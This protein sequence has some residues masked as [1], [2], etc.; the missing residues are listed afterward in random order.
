MSDTSSPRLTDSPWYWAYLFAMA[1]LIALVLIGPKFARRQAIIET[2]SE[3]R[4]RASMNL[5][6]RSL[7]PANED[8]SPRIPLG[9]LYLVLALLLGVAGFQLWRRRRRGAGPH[10]PENAASPSSGP[11]LTT[12]QLP[13]ATESASTSIPRASPAALD[14]PTQ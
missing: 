2:K 9:P 6:G 13:A 11:G 1:G 3:A 12:P 5:S 8:R 14:T 10:P 4:Q 7:P